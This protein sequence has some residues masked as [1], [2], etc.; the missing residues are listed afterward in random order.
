MIRKSKSHNR[1]YIALLVIFSIA[2][3]AVL[4]WQAGREP[5]EPAWE[6][7]ALA[8]NAH[9]ATPTS[10]PGWWQQ[11]SPRPLVPTMP[12]RLPQ[13]SPTPINTEIP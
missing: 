4:G 12:G 6:M 13:I 5:L 3:L 7:P 2:G 9:T 11:I 8:A 1:I 10:T